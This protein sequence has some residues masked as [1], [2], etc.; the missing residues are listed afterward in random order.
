MIK[1]Y[2]VCYF[3]ILNYDLRNLKI[4]KS[5]Y[6]FYSFN[7]P[8]QVDSD[9]KKNI[10]I[11]FA[12]LGY[13]FNRNSLEKFDNLKVICSNTTGHPHIDLVYAKKRNIKV[14]C[15][16][17]YQDFLKTITPTAEFSFILGLT[18]YRNIIKANSSLRKSFI[19]DRKLYPS[20][21]MINKLNIGIIGLG[22]IGTMLSNYFNFFNSNVYFYSPM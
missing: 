11:L 14:I 15:L 10:D 12:P 1:K 18:L 20:P 7:N 16:K 3:D 17:F 6:N 19:W 2:N 4:L 9:I 5:N 21:S 22:R 8:N 13:S